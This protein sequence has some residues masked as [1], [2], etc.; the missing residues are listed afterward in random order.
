MHA[1]E[2]LEFRVIGADGGLLERAL[3][4]REMFLSPSERA[5]VLLDLRGA[6]LGDRVTLASLPFDAMQFSGMS[7]ASES[8]P[9]SN[10]SPLEIMLIRVTRKVHYERTVP[11]VLSKPGLIEPHD[12]QRRRF[13]FDHVKGHWHIN[14]QSYRM[15]DTAFSVKRGAREIW[16]FRNEKPAMPHPVHVH[17]FQYRVLD[18][19][20]SPAQTHALA[21]NDR[22]LSAT[23]LGWKDTVLLWPGE[24][25]RLLLDFSHPFRGDQVYML[26]C[27][28]LQ[29]ETQGMMV[30][31]RI[32][33]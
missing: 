30:N 24:K 32:E 21:L 17:G 19:E 10:G 27:H 1:D 12:A 8:S 15:T 9:A 29:H 13:F 16:E 4:A 3:P 23:E 20:G 26:Q 18:R 22:G 33:A 2:P 5:D 31:F 25:V 7:H 14:G 11:D 6:A 28:N